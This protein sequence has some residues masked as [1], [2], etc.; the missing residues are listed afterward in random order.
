M[1]QC[2]STRTAILAALLLCAPVLASAQV[3]AVE[4][5][6]R[7]TVS[8]YTGV[9]APFG[10]GL[11]SVFVPSGE[12][13]VRQDRS[14]SPLLGVDAKLRMGGRVSLLAGGLYTQTGQVQYFLSDTAFSQP[15]DWIS[16]STDPMWFAKLGA[17]ARFEPGHSI[18]EPRWR[19]ST[20]IFAAA[21]VVREFEKIHPAVNFGFQGSLAMARG[22]EMTV[23]L[24]D[25]LVFWNEGRLAPAVAGIVQGFQEEEVQDVVLYYSTSNIFQLHVGLTLKAW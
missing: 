16:Q 15:P 4:A 8:A 23:G 13:L 2:Y 9:R 6:P 24:E 17:S 5:L 14:G 11:A 18:T 19:P 20:D 22:V 12:F 25:Y 1:K 10:G 21:A 3:G 7:L